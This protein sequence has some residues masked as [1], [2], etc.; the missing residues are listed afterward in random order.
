MALM[1]VEGVSAS[2]RV[3][4]LRTHTRSPDSLVLRRAL[5][6]YG[7]ACRSLFRGE[8]TRINQG[9]IYRCYKVNQ[10]GS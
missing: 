1:I 8:L 10:L 5:Q 2:L 6:F 7:R 4:L 3:G 9:P